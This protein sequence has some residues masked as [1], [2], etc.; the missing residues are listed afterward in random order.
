MFENRK[1]LT[2]RIA[3]L[4]ARN[5]ELEASLET[6][7]NE[8]TANAETAAEAVAA[9]DAAQ[10]ELQEVR[11]DLLATNEDLGAAKAE[12]EKLTAEIADD[13]DRVSKEA[14]K[15]LAELG[16]DPIEESEEGAITDKQIRD[17]FDAMK[18]GAERTAFYQQHRDALAK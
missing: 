10:A 1:E 14:A 3:A 9:K 15:Q 12:N 7:T 6:A 16:H 11:E 8:A 4:E 5:D 17:Q 13:A 2:E 18:A